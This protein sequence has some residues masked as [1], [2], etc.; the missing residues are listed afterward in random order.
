[1]LRSLLNG[2]IRSRTGASTGRG[3]GAGYGG[4]PRSG[5]GGGRGMQG[6]ALGALASRFLRRR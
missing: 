3:H 5:Y 4:T 6:A 1:M 2:V